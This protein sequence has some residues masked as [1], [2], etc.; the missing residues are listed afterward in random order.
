M[1]AAATLLTD[2]FEYKTYI[3]L[4]YNVMGDM[5][6]IYFHFLHNVYNSPDE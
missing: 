1:S 5:C 4:L 2:N 6:I 3:I